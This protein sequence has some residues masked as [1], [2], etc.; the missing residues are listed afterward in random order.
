MFGPDA[1][2]IVKVLSKCPP[3][4]YLDRFWMC[5]DWRPYVL[6]GCD[7]LHNNRTLASGTREF[8]TKQVA[9]TRTKY[10][11]LFERMVGLTPAEYRPRIQW[12]HD[13]VM[14]ETERQAALLETQPT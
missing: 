3:E 12:L 6:K 10:Y 4:G 11:P 13:A 2:T 1:T 5:A 14:K 7:R 8:R 9:E